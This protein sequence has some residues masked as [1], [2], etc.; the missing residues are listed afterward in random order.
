MENNDNNLRENLKK[1]TPEQLADLKI[2][3]DEMIRRAD[4]LVEEC[5][6]ILNDNME[7]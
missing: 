3:N 6:D 4:E 2:E 5:N 1:I 7:E